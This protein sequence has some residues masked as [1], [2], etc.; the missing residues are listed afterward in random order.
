MAQVISTQTH[1]A[2]TPSV[3]RLVDATGCHSPA[4]PQEITGQLR[5]TTFAWLDLENPDDDQLHQYGHALQLDPDT[6]HRL[7]R[8]GDRPS[9]TPIADSIQVAPPGAGSSTPRSAAPILVSA[10]FTGRYLLTLHAVPCPPLQEARDRYSTLQDNAK[11]DGPLVLFLVLDSLISSFEPQVLALDKRLD[12]IQEALLD[13]GS[14]PNMHDEILRIRRTLNMAGQ[15]LTWY[16]ND[17]EDLAGRVEHLPGMRPGAQA[18]FDRHQRHA[19]RIRDAAK[20]YRDEA[21][22]ALGQF[23]SNT[24]N[25]QGQLINVLTVVATFFLPLTFI[26]SFFGMNFSVMTMDLRTNLQ[27][28]LLGV[29]LPAA[30]VVV[31]LLLY[32]RLTRRLEVGNLR[33]PPS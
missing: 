17:L 19:V 5:S 28:I 22:D 11:S 26:T 18:H 2:T 15:A 13:G 12:E 25:R 20:D 30:S 14:P 1:Q 9:F 33:Q 4:T 31:T 3:A 10:V 32:R 23:S 24:A 8:A 6:I 21:K 16:A 7:R 27:F 29:V